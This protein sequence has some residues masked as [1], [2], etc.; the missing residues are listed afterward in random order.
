MT[1]EQIIWAA[2]L[3]IAVFVVLPILVNLLERARLAARNIERYTAEALIA[4]VGIADDAKVRLQ[5]GRGHIVLG[6]ALL[7]GDRDG[8][9]PPFC[10]RHCVPLSFPGA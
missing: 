3:V 7:A 5:L 6:H 8:P 9:N 2:T 4:G 1:I 10:S